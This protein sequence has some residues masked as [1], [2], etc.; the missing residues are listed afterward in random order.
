VA[1]NSGGTLA[2]GNPLGPLTINNSLTLAPGSMTFVQ[3]QH[4]PLTN[5]AVKISGAL[6]AGGTLNVT[7]IGGPL[8]AGDNFQLFNAAGY[9]G[10]FA[11]MILPPLTGNLVWNTNRLATAGT[12]SVAA[13][14]PPAIGQINLNSTNLTISGSGGIAGWTYYVLAATNLAAA[15]TPIASNQFDANGNFN[16]TNA[17]DSG[18]P[19]TFYRLQ[20]Q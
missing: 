3:V 17:V 19:Q 14:L 15:W 9:S 1:V 5:S 20:L 11:G 4:S 12:L 7:N 8:A 16:V 2:P 6:L 13:Y 18:A 10:S